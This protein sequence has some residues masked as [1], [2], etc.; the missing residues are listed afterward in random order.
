MKIQFVI[1]VILVYSSCS[2]DPDLP[3]LSGGKDLK[4]TGALLQYFNDSFPVQKERFVIFPISPADTLRL[5][6]NSSYTAILF[7]WSG[8]DTLNTFISEKGAF[9]NFQYD[10]SLTAGSNFTIGTTDKDLNN[11]SLGLKSKWIIGKQVSDSV[12]LTISG[13]YYKEN[14]KGFGVRS[15]SLFQTRVNIKLG[16]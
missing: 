1:L 7:L 10:I 12:I 15:D 9:Y 2:K 3:A 4:I 11:L 6:T 16:K 5:D 8:S 14:T 13:V